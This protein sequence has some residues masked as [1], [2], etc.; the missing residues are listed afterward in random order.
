[1]QARLLSEGRVLRA[2]DGDTLLCRIICPCCKV[3]SEQRVRLARIDAP[4][5]RGPEHTAAALAKR[6]LAAQVAQGRAQFAVRRAWPDRYGRVIA[7]VIVDGRNMSD[8][9][10]EA[11]LA[12]LWKEDSD[13]AQ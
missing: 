12:R 8:A 13:E 9:M 5:L 6:Y 7:E 1:M 2:I 10:L 11:G 4:E 3:E